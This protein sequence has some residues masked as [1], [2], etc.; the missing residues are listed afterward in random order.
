M[1]EKVI[2]NLGVDD[3]ILK[4][5]TAKDIVRKYGKA[6]DF[7]DIDG[8]SLEMKFMLQ[9]FSC[10]F[11]QKDPDMKIHVVRMWKDCPAFQKHNDEVASGFGE[12][13]SLHDVFTFYREQVESRN[14]YDGTCY[15]DY[16][17]Y[18]YHFIPEGAPDEYIPIES[19]VIKR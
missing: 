5:T 7:Y 1:L 14:S 15:V 10:F 19:I 11:L 3:I 2:H 13:M 8:N 17:F 12:A 6:Y 4:Q 9:D 16:G 18:R